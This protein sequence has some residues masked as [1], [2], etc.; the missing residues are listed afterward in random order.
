MWGI[1]GTLDDSIITGLAE[2]YSKQP[3]MHDGITKAPAALIEEGKKLFQNGI[4]S[5]NIP[6]CAF[7]HGEH[8]NGA[9]I[10][11]R[12][13]GQHAEYLVRQ[14]TVIQDN[15]RKSPVMHGIV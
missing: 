5:R 4:P 1:A 11:P 7:C 3:P 15:L 2:Y 14:L 13:A 8:A 12:L 6:A 10:F 9:A